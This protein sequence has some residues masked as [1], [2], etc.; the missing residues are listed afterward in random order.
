MG[1]Q[2]G[3]DLHN[4]VLLKPHY[5]LLMPQA[6]LTLAN[7]FLLLLLHDYGNMAASAQPVLLGEAI[8]NSNREAP[9][10]RGHLTDL[11]I[12]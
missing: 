6:V 8:C 2:A 11:H 3:E 5:E 9:I 7:F 4:I 12:T 10:P 1:F